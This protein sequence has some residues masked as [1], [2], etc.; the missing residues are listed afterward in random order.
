[1][2]FSITGAPA[3]TLTPPPTPAA[4]MPSNAR[5]AVIASALMPTTSFG[6]P[7]RCTSPA[8]TMVVTPP[9]RHDSIQPSWFW[10]GVQSPNTG[11]TCESI[12]P[13]ASAVPRASITR[14]ARSV[15]Q[16]CSRPSAAIRP[17]SITTVSASRI[18]RSMSPDSISPTLRI[19]TLPD[20]SVPAAIA[21]SLLPVRVPRAAD[22]AGAAASAGRPCL[23]FRGAAIH[24]CAPAGARCR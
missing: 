12:R 15:S 4:R 3:S 5:C 18:G 7:G 22:A 21:I 23:R 13:G 17:S 6:R 24:R 11:C 1:M 8:D 2:P 10:R 9:C 16:S 19:T 14:A 20:F